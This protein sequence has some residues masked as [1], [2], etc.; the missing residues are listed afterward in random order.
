MI[1]NDISAEVEFALRAHDDRPAIVEVQPMVGGCIHPS[2]CLRTAS[3]GRAFL[4]WGRS[5]GPAGFRAEVDGLRALSRASGP[6]TPTILGFQPGQPASRGWI[7]LEFIRAGVQRADSAK[8]LG[9]ALARLHRPLPESVPGWDRDGFIGVLL[10]PN[11]AEGAHW[12]EFWREKRLATQWQKARGHFSK[13]GH[14]DW[15]QL[16]ELVG[17]ALSACEN[18]GL[19]LLHGDLWHG[20]VITDWTG[21]PVLIDPAVYRGHR[22]VD[23]AMMELF[24]GFPA[25]V[26]EGYESQTAVSEEYREFRRDVYQLYPLL[27]HVNLFGRAY[28]GAV[29]DRVRRLLRTLG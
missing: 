20:N 1:P 26:F 8:R 21:D 3:G 16:M 29:R 9:S 24:G 10:Q 2:A 22:E 27:V 4:K 6:R 5:M 17:P 15:H 18:D 23:L 19:S 11:R 25:E 12:P 13:S 28:V 7:L 14:R